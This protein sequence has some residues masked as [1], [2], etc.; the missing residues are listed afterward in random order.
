L[1]LHLVRRCGPW[2]LVSGSKICKQNLALCEATSLEISISAVDKL[3]ALSAHSR[4]ELLQCSVSINNTDAGG[5]QACSARGV[6]SWPRVA[7]KA[8]C[9][10]GPKCSFRIGPRIPSTNVQA[11]LPPAVRRFQFP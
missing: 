6:L 10:P 5:S 2:G 3:T 11:V 7:K 8:L 9:V 4:P 1:I